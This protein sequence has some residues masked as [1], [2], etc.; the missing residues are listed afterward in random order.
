MM[1]EVL[2]YQAYS[3]ENDMTT[4]FEEVYET[5]KLESVEVK[6]FYYG[7]PNNEAKEQFYGKLKAEF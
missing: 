1:K 3:S 4:I 5:G 6:G 2:I 7:K